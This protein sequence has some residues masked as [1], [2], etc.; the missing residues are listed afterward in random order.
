MQLVLMSLSPG[1]E[2]GMEIH[3]HTSQFIR[4]E[5]G[6]ARVYIGRKM[7]ILRDGDAVIIPPRKKHKIINNGHEDLKLYTIYSPPEHPKNR[8]QKFPST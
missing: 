1:E 3:P 7:Y 6:M 5:S 8:K 4:V 2:I